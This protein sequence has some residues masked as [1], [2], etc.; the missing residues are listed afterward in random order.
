MP[1]INLI[2]AAVLGA[3]VVLQEETPAAAASPSD[4]EDS[5]SGR[6]SPHDDAGAHPLCQQ[7]AGARVS[8]VVEADHG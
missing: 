6:G 2:L 8:E 4:D 1:R 3:S 5:V 7:E